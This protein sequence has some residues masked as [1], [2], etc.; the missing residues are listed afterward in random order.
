MRSIT[1]PEHVFGIC[2][3]RST[4]FSHAGKR[5]L[6]KFERWRKCNMA[7]TDSRR[8]S[9]QVTEHSDALDLRQHIFAHTDPSAIARSLKC[10]WWRAKCPSKTR[11][12]HPAI[13]RAA[14]LQSRCRYG[15]RVRIRQWQSRS[16][17]LDGRCGAGHRQRNAVREF[18][19]W[20]V[21]RHAGKCSP[22]VFR[23]WKVINGNS[24]C[25]DRP[26]RQ[27]RESGRR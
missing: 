8:W 15:P 3:S 6:P 20:P 7:T 22:R 4:S 9:K 2:L 18:R 24:R 16:R 21:G 13:G 26:R 17:R 23:R 19:L 12:Y 5:R 25:L 11:S 1:P 10:P 27:I 14:P